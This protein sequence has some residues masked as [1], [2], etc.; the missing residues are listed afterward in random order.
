VETLK[1]QYQMKSLKRV[2]ALGLVLVFSTGQQAWAAQQKEED[3]VYRWGRWSVLSPAAGGDSYEGS[4]TP[5]AANNAR[6]SDAD[7]FQP[8]VASVGIPPVQ[9]PI[10][11]PVQPPIEPPVDVVES[12][13]AGAA[14]G[15]ATY[16]R[17]EGDGAKNG[18]VLASFDLSSKQV[19]DPGG[20]PVTGPGV[21]VTNFSVTDS[22]DA[23]FPDVES[24]DMVG[25]FVDGG[26]DITGTQVSSTID[27]ELGAIVSDGETSTLSHSNQDT[28]QVY[29]FNGVDA[30]Y[31]RQLAQ[32]RVSY[33]AGDLAGTSETKTI[34]DSDGYFVQGLVATVEQMETF[35]AG[36]VSATYNGFVLDYASP[37]QLNFNFDNRTFNGN[38][39][40][41][42][43]FNGFAI[44]GAVK[45]V[46][47]SAADAGKEVVGSFFNGG[48]NASGAVNN[49]TQQ[50]VFS[51]DLAGAN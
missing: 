47:F 20:G 51:T 38:F 45:G 3:S 24:A 48:L 44:D 31:W 25:A 46:N 41:A 12:C 36:R 11:P 7:E 27:S 49:G 21:T 34:S 5:D 39:G 43:G 35:A 8:K 50:G 15:F 37:V 28:G 19:S 13:T 6:P 16:S 9:P 33:F 10:E 40:T 30:G 1:D 4:V 14:C 26:P 29:D 32:Q 17:Q 23:A 18:P 2:A 22:G 42:N